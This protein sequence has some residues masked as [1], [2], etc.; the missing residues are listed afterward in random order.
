[1]ALTALSQQDDALARTVPAAAAAASPVTVTAEHAG[2]EI[3]RTRTYTLNITYDNY[4]RTPRLWLQGFD[5]VSD[6]APAGD[7]RRSTIRRDWLSWLQSR[8]MFY[9]PGLVVMVTELPAVL[10]DGT[11]C[12][13]YRMASQLFYVTGLVVTC[14]GYRVASC[15]I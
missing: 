6:P 9:M 10:Y 1:M 2:E 5:E 7:V 3:V 11:G 14:H 13:G 15:P 4:Y 8:Q 12:H